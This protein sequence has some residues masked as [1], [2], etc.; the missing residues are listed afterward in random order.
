[1]VKECEGK[2]EGAEILQW[3]AFGVWHLWK[4]RNSCVFQNKMES[5][6]QMIDKNLVQG[7]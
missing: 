7:Y 2:E 3:C 6:M 5:P 4:N 1:M